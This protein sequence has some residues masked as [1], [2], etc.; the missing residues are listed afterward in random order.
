MNE[1]HLFE[2][3]QVLADVQLQLLVLN[4]CVLAL[5]RSYYILEYHSAWTRV[6]RKP[7]ATTGRVDLA[8]H[9]LLDVE[10]DGCSIFEMSC[11]D[12]R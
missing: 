2:F 1:F 4:I 7:N 11:P 6:D 8:K 5:Q 3:V 9:S 12:V 10:H